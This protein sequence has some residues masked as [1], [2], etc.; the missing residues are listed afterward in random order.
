MDAFCRVNH[1]VGTQ[2]Q[3][4]PEKGKRPV[5]DWVLP[6]GVALFFVA[7]GVDKFIAAP[8]SEWGSIFAKIGW[9]DWFCYFTGGIETLG[10]LVIFIP[11]TTLAGTALLA[12]AMLGGILAHCFKLG[13]PFASIIPLVLLVI[14]V[15]VGRTLSSKPEEFSGL[16]LQRF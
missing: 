9:G 12:S 4:E 7:V 15:I 13:D 2:P 8:Q 5:T 10:A 11:K 16:G 1:M 3:M 6:F 14:V